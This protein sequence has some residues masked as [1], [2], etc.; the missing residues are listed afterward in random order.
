M[1][2]LAGVH[3]NTVRLYEE[4]G[5]ISPVKRLPNGYRI[6]SEVHLFQLRI[7]RTAY[8]CEVIQGNL[9]KTAR[10][11]VVASGGE[12][13][14]L[15]YRLAS[16]YQRGVQAEYAKAL[17]AIAIAE[18]C[19]AGVQPSSQETWTRKEAALLLDVSAEVIRNWERNGLVA[20]PRQAN[21]SRIY[22]VSEMERMKL[23]RALRAA[24][25]SSSA[26]LRL[27]LQTDDCH[28]QDINVKQVLDTPA[29]HE[30]IVTVTDRL[31]HSL[32]EALIAAEQ[33]L[34]LLAP[35]AVHPVTI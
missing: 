12:A 26:I 35:Y 9:R 33:L 1:A 19:L 14:D 34:A 27:L 20:V 5:V 32:E 7:A 8:R 15:A 22:T 11:I 6:F 30:D 17:E 2:D 3:P 16:E 23:I 29:P 28:Q 24:S 13:F 18:R 10:A 25:Y 31:T 21:G 4:W